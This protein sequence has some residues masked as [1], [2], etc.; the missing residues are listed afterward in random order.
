MGV[1]PGE[2]LAA[3]RSGEVVPFVG[4]GLSVS[5]DRTLFPGWKELVQALAD[6]T[7]DEKLDASKIAQAIAQGKLEDAAQHALD[8]LG[9]K[10]FGGVVVDKFGKGWNDAVNADLSA[11][12]AL[13][14]LRPPV[15]ITT[16]Y[17][18]VLTWPWDV[19]PSLPLG[20]ASA[21][22]TPVYNDDPA[23]LASL[24]QHTDREHP[25]VWHLHGAVSRTDTVVL[26]R[27]QYDALYP[28]AGADPSLA[29]TRLRDFIAGRTLLFV[30]YSLED[31]LVMRQVQ[32]VLELTK[33]Y[34]SKSYVLAKKDAI[35]P[36][37][38]FKDLNTQV[39]EFED[40]GLPLIERLQAIRVEAWP[41]EPLRPEAVSRDGFQGLWN[42]LFARLRGVACAPADVGEAFAAAKPDDVARIECRGDGVSLLYTAI[43]QVAR[44][45]VGR[46][47]RHPLVRF[48]GG[49]VPA[50][51]EEHRA[52]VQ[53]WLDAA[54]PELASAP[55]EAAAR[56][57]AGPAYVLVRVAEDEDAGPQHWDVE[58]W[59]DCGAGM[60]ALFAD[61]F[62]AGDF[63]GV[64]DRLALRLIQ[65]RVAR[66]ETTVAFLLPR[67]WLCHPVHGLA[68]TP[69]QVPEPPL[70]KRHRVV[71][72]SLERTR[73]PRARALLDQAWQR[74]MA[75]G[76]APLD[77]TDSDLAG[78]ANL[79][80]GVWLRAPDSE[81]PALLQTVADGESTCVV[82]EPGS[83]EWP[84]DSKALDTLLQ[85]GV[86]VVLW[87]RKKGEVDLRQTARDALAQVPLHDLPQRICD[88]RKQSHEPL[89]LTLLY[90][91]ADRMPPHGSDYSID[92]R[93][94]DG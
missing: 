50:L 16:N 38:A 17:D 73:S 58:A 74:W 27:S 28:Q 30:G 55:H 23:E 79:E 81:H 25:R 84:P 92:R 29:V 51:R 20:V 88:W 13:W 31:E 8:G 2:L 10:L 86:P 91:D 6:K 4:A 21:R 3:V 39:M 49:V 61:R 76:G 37:T 43:A 67:A 18:S 57:P 63:Q 15:V 1:T 80:R 53:E 59:V 32:R 46:D 33:G 45:C 40:F 82:L 14:R 71:V 7:I 56:A 90:D 44:Y 52:S 11:V 83:D 85:A 5:V 41:D 69:E 54:M 47:G 78:G 89:G 26:A 35:D 22:P 36:K 65:E 66:P 9:K 68:P 70:G 34:A 48:L 94:N 77:L 42:D 87:V 12:S 72:R 60:T 93:T 62:A 64:T 19:R 75:E 24:A